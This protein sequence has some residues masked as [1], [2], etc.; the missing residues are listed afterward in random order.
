M[1]EE[2]KAFF[3]SS[4]VSRFSRPVL[5]LRDFI[6]RQTRICNYATAR[7]STDVTSTRSHLS[8]YLLVF[9]FIANV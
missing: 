3:L 8:S 9:R 6:V 4:S 2:A 7:P 5:E 1:M